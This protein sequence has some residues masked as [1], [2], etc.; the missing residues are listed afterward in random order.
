MYSIHL[1]YYTTQE[2]NSQ[3]VHIFV[4][5]SLC[6]KWDFLDLAF[7]TGVA[8]FLPDPQANYSHTTRTLNSYAHNFMYMFM[9]VQSR[10]RIHMC[11]FVYAHVQF[12]ARRLCSRCLASFVLFHIHPVHFLLVAVSYAYTNDAKALSNNHRSNEIII[13]C[14]LKQHVW[15]LL[16]VVPLSSFALSYSLSLSKS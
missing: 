3:E 1:G 13:T 11:V 9:Y 7:V 12:A 6:F 10:G 8:L 16:L 2:S 5:T 14:K 15:L 4:S